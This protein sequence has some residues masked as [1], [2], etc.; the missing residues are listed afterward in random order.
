METNTVR[1]DATP[2]Q[3]TV[4]SSDNTLPPISQLLTELLVAVLQFALPQADFTSQSAS[5]HTRICMKMLYIMR[6]VA[7]RWQDIIEGTPSFW[8][9]IL[10]TLPSHVN[11]A[12]IRHSA[13]L[14][15]SVIYQ[16][17]GSANAAKYP[18]A[19]EFLDTIV[20]TRQRWSAIALYGTTNMSGYIGDPAPLLQ[21]IIVRE[22]FP[23]DHTV[24]SLEL[25][26]GDTT[27][28]RHI[29]LSDV[30]IHWKMGCLAQLRCLILRRVVNDGLTGSH[31]LDILRASPGL[32]VLKLE[33]IRTDIPP[34]SPVITLHQLKCINLD[35]CPIG[36][37]QFIL[38]HIRAPSCTKLGLCIDNE[39]VFD[40]SRFINETM[41]PFSGILLAIH[42]R[43]RESEI[44]LDSDGFYWYTLSS[45]N[46]NQGLSILIKDQFGPLFIRWV[47]RILQNE[48]GLR[49]N[50]GD[51]ATSSEAMLGSV[52]HMRCATKVL[53]GGGRP[54]ED[55]SQMLKFLG[56]PLKTSSSLPSLPCLRELIIKSVSWSIQDLLDMVQSRFCG[57]S[58]E[59]VERT[60][61]TILLERGTFSWARVAWPIIELTT[62]ARIREMDGVGCIRLV[63]GARD[64][65]GMLAVKWDE[66]ASRPVWV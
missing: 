17:P 48:P 16:Y 34:N 61:L 11:E 18:S 55:V 64:S 37:V 14:S 46:A 63:G 44:R 15:L 56:Q 35:S 42:K 4:L 40:A 62:L 2:D 23:S 59:T 53:I 21:T 22:P 54:R 27:H 25:L 20:H 24:Q 19:P 66:E 5:F 12:S 51:G 8:T 1:N 43:S 57:L 6:S 7:K 38:Q 31:L 3:V 47:D 39:R 30:T 9:T 29:D 13:D 45:S 49:I 52:A 65:G 36:L 28:L 26:G 50:F 60:L 58:K 32:Q 10:S 41:N 33:E